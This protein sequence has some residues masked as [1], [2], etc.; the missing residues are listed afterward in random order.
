M[1]CESGNSA[2]PASLAEPPGPV[3]PFPSFSMSNVKSSS[4]LSVVSVLADAAEAEGA[5]PD[6]LRPVAAATP[7]AA[8]G[9]PAS[10]C[11]R[12]RTDEEDFSSWRGEV[13][14]VEF[15]IFIKCRRWRA[16][17]SRKRGQQHPFNYQ[18]IS[19]PHCGLRK[20][21]AF[22]FLP[23]LWHFSVRKRS[24]LWRPKVGG[25]GC[26]KSARLEAR[27]L[28]SGSLSQRHDRTQPGDLTDER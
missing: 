18:P 13:E 4:S 14:E 11:R 22:H 2:I 23:N 25:S 16:G 15:G 24:E 12:L 21:K 5:K 17:C 19:G 8:S 27:E 7:N 28:R 20:R 10:N 9:A 26:R 3:Q 6:K 1:L